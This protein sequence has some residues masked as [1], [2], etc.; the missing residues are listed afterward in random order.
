[1]S[2]HEKLNDESKR[3]AELEG[4]K[5]ELMAKRQQN[6]ITMFRQKEALL[7]VFEQMQRRRNWEQLSK[8]TGSMSAGGSGDASKRHLSDSSGALSFG[9]SSNGAGSAGGDRPVDLL[10]ALSG[11]NKLASSSKARENSA[12][13]PRRN[14]SIDDYLANHN[15]QTQMHKSRSGML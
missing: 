6:S 1:M 11:L 15:K 2:L 3:L 12:S 13:R 14:A 4:Q 7:R 9:S 5:R 10:G 8:L